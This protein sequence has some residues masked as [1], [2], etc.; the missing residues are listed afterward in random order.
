[1]IPAGPGST[2][3]FVM[4]IAEL[5]VWRSQWRDLSAVGVVGGAG[6]TCNNVSDGRYDAGLA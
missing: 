4:H 5:P 2:L 6:G 1:M 3:Q